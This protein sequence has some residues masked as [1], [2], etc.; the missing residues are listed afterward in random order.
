MKLDWSV[1]IFRQRISYGI[2]LFCHR[3]N[4]CTHEHRHTRIRVIVLGWCSCWDIELG[5]DS[6]WAPTRK[7]ST[8]NEFWCYPSLSAH[9]FAFGK[10]NYSIGLDVYV[11]LVIF[12]RSL[13]HKLFS[14]F[15]FL[16]WWTIE[17]DNGVWK[18]YLVWRILNYVLENNATIEFQT[19]I[20]TK[21]KWLAKKTVRHQYIRH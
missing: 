9:S 14:F 13:K 5:V 8:C 17:F 11:R 4:S 21:H 1:H 20:A 12:T 6:Y 19:K 7:T 10:F 16:K 3:A 2:C 18:L 15:F